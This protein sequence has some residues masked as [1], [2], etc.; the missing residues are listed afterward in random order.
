MYF[1]NVREL[2]VQTPKV[3][4]RVRNGEKI[5]ITNRGK[6]QAVM[7]HLTEDEIED[8]AFRQPAF[9][10]EIEDARKEYRKKGG[11][12]SAELRRQLGI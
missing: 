4:R 2:R 10:K 9:L 1:V 3:L 7:L 6:P 11:M 5:V 8:L 12:T